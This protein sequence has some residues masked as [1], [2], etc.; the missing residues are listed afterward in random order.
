MTLADIFDPSGLAVVG[1]SATEGKIGCEAMA[2]AA[3]FDGPVYPINPSGDG[4]LF[5]KPFRA[6]LIQETTDP[7][8]HNA[9]EVYF[10]IEG[11]G[12]THVDGQTLAWGEQGIFIVPPDAT[13]HHEPD[14]EAILLGI[15]DRPVYEALN[16]YAEAEPSS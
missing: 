7:H 12:A 11:E 15:T 10:V 6:Q 8:F 16:F 9:V 3:A 4:N 13:H 1:A 5:G 14:D 2:N